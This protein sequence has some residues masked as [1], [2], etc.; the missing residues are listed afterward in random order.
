MPFQGPQAAIT[1]KVLPARDAVGV[2]AAGWRRGDHSRGGWDFLPKI[3]QNF[4]GVIAELEGTGLGVEN[5]MPR[6]GW[7]AGGYFVTD[8]L[9]IESGI[10]SM[11]QATR[12]THRLGGFSIATRNPMGPTDSKSLRVASMYVSIALPKL[13]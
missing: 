2:L 11:R 9:R 4:F 7:S 12:R 1:H 3:S 8:G 10:H 5:Y 13:E 6:Q